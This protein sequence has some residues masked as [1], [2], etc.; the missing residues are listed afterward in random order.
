MTT[1]ECELKSALVF[2][3]I[4]IDALL[5]SVI[6]LIVLFSSTRMPCCS[7]GSSVAMYAGC[8]YTLDFGVCCLY[9]VIS[10]DVSMFVLKM[11]V[12]L[13]QFSASPFCK[14]RCGS[15]LCARRPILLCVRQ[16]RKLLPGSAV[17]YCLT[18]CSVLHT[19]RSSPV[20]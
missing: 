4:S 7:F 13:P 12:A 3:E 10:A 20:R 16:D 18:T 9:A 11:L 2:A 1:D 17:C 14:S 5:H 6:S 19:P 15:S 8:Y